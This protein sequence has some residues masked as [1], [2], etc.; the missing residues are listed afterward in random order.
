[1]TPQAPRVADDEWWD[2]RLVAVR[3]RDRGA[4]PPLPPASDRR[5]AGAFAVDVVLHLTIGIV[6]ALRWGLPF[7]IT[8]IAVFTVVSFVH[9]VLLQRWWGTTI[10]GALFGV[11][12]VD[13]RTGVKATLG[14][15]LKAW[16]VTG[17]IAV[18]TVV[19]PLL[20][21]FP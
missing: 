4:A 21:L 2:F 20:G 19:I 7:L 15:L 12:R 9:R 18:I 11:L 14:G 6:V 3:R 5:W 1:M 16:L 13:K 8:A 17:Y 10:A